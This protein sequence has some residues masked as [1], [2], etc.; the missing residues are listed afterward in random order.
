MTAK[1]ETAP[2][3]LYKSKRKRR[4]LHVGELETITQ[5]RVTAL[6]LRKSG[7]SYRDIAKAIGVSVKTAYVDVQTVLCELRETTRGHAEEVMAV[8]L[9]RCDR[10]LE[11]FW[12][13]AMKGDPV[14]GAMVLKVLDRRAKYLGLDSA[15]RVEQQTTIVDH[16]SVRTALNDKIAALA[17]RLTAGASVQPE[18]RGDISLA[19]PV[20]KLLNE[21]TA[22]AGGNVGKPV[23]VGAA[24]IIPA[25]LPAPP[26]HWRSASAED[27]AAAAAVLQDV[28]SG[29]LAWKLGQ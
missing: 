24:D 18:P 16:A 20:V 26:K 21:A 23:N 15:V 9:E 12:P 3:P 17:V 5:R 28:Q 10:L 7:L 11:S 29:A 2:K 22:E 1:V 4:P 27:D 8:E 13:E 14:A 25:T 6:E 19:P